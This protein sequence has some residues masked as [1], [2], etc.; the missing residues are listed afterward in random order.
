MLENAA[1][2][3][4]P[5]TTVKKSSFQLYGMPWYYF[6]IF[7]LAV[8]TATYLGKLPAGMIGA[9]PL[10][11]VL[12][13]YFNLVG[14]K[15]PFIN[16]FLGGGAIVIIFGSAALAT[17]N[18][19]PKQSVTT[20]S[21]FMKGGGFLDFYIAALITGSIMGMSRQLLIKAA[22]RYLP[23]ILGGVLVSLSL[24]S[25]F[26]YLTGFGAKKAL[27]FVSIPIMGGGMGAGAVP[28]SKIFGEGL[29]TDP[30]TMLSIMVP[31][32]ALGN[33]LAIIFGGLLNKLGHIKPSLSGNG[34][35]MVLGNTKANA[36]LEKEEEEQSSRDKID[37]AK[38]GTGLLIA[39][40]FFVFG[41]ILNLIFPAIHGYAW[42]ILSVAV[43]KVSGLLNTKMETCC[44][45]W[46]QFVMKN[47]TGVLL[48]GIGV[49]Y[50]NLNEVA[51]AFSGQYVLLVS[52]TVIGA[53]I[54]AGIVGRFVGFFSIE[55]AITGGL[56]MANMGGTGDVA[57]L[58]AAKRMELMPFAQISSRIGGAFMLILSSIILQFFA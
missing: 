28:L 48:V 5:V 26:G 52:V 20:M 58:S 37:L 35:L 18:V 33:A 10:M 1:A 36:E 39:T 42:M 14:D 11:I 43:V 46:F 4:S 32:V 27:F 24:G 51:A 50:T 25:L 12:G 38:M 54:G 55:S 15:T 23:V 31:A 47:L 8:L 6:A 34:Q 30:A 22:F 17:F 56:C 45:Q 57:V 7:S 13:T 2:L 29:G 44:Y 40:T 16:T 41:A 9:F 21:E 49:A 3:S 53:I 19:L